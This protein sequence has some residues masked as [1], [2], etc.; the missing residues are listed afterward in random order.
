MHI[1][2][3]IK[4]FN[5]LYPDVDKFDVA[6]DETIARYETMFGY[7]LPP[8]F[9][10]F[11]KE[12]SNGIF[13]LDWEPI[14]GVSNDSPCGEIC[15]VNN[16]IPDVPKEVI[17]VET[18]EIID[19]ER[20]VSFTLFDAGETSNNHWV[21]LC[22]DNIPNNDYRVGFISQTS[23]K[24]VKV[25]DNFEEWLSIFWEINKDD[26]IGKPVFYSFFPTFDDRVEILDL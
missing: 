5:N 2:E 17:I 24:I 9:I 8:S 11:L 13:L 26:E 22:E 1:S 16:L 18:N 10:Q 20:L 25:L 6:T 15:K 12:F 19:T 14:G 3:F 23:H 21:F 7:H 4:Q